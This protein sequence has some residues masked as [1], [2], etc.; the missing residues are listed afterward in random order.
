MKALVIYYSWK[1][2]TRAVAE[3]LKEIGGFELRRIEEVIIRRG[4]FSHIISAIQAI[5]DFSSDLRPYNQGLEGFDK[6]FIGTPVWA[7]NPAP[8]IN[9]FIKETDLKNIKF[10][11]FCTYLL[12]KPIRAVNKLENNIKEKGGKIE[13][14]FFIKVNKKDKNLLKEKVGESIKKYI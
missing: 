10:V 8:A 7:G 13:G 3:V 2:H 14:S 5:A 12:S 6:V 11:I 1:N 4:V 9:T